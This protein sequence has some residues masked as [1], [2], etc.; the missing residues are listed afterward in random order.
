MALEWKMGP[1]P[2]RKKEELEE[3]P[4]CEDRLVR[5]A[6]QEDMKKRSGEVRV[7]QKSIN[8]LKREVVIDICEPWVE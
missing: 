3:D 8:V 2:K 4:K 6:N 1:C 5:K 7:E